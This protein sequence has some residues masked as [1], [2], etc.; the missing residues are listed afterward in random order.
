M[1]APPG[2]E[3]LVV[4]DMGGWGHTDGRLLLLDP[5]APEGRR[6]KEALTGLEYPFGLAIGPDKKV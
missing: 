2:H 6:I 1:T 3:Q 4:A 5:R